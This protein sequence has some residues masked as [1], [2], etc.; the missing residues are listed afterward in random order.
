MTAHCADDPFAAA[1]SPGWWEGSRDTRRLWALLARLAGAGA[2]RVA[3][4]THPGFARALLG[5][6]GREDAAPRCPGA[7]VRTAWVA[8]G[9][10]APQTPPQAEAPAQ[11]QHSAQQQE[12]EQEQ[13]AH[14]AT[15]AAPPPP[16]PAQPP[17][18][19]SSSCSSGSSSIPAR[20]APVGA[21]LSAQLAQ[22]AVQ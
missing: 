17:Q 12:Q 22:L 18:Q 5:F 6:A 7:W 16:V 1:T 21:A 2:A 19:R 9:G 20:S 4:V 8:A 13:A 14:A 10:E 15:D 3:L 11:Q